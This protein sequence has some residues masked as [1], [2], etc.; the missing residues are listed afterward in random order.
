MGCPFA[1]D[2]PAA[3]GKLLCCA[4][5]ENGRVDECLQ[6]FLLCDLAKSPMGLAD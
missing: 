3:R 4:H 2:F 6:Y 5:P 1:K